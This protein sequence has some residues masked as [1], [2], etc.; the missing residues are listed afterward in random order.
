MN[1]DFLEDL[2]E[3]ENEEDSQGLVSF[4][5]LIISK[6]KL[7]FVTFLFIFINS[8]LYTTYK[9]YFQPLYRGR[10]T[11]LIT[12]PLKDKQSNNFGL[13]GQGD[14][15]SKL[16]LNTT[17]NDTTTL[18]EVLKSQNIIKPIAEKYN[19]KPR[20]LARRIKIKVGGG[21]KRFERAEGILKVSLTGRRP[22]KT[23]VILEDLSELYLQTA[24][25][26]RQKKLSDGLQFLNDQ[27]PALKDKTLEI[28]T[29]LEE[30]RIKNQLIEPIIESKILK[31]NQINFENKVR[32]LSSEKERLKRIREEIVKGNL[33]A[34]S[35]KKDIIAT[36]SENNFRKNGLD[37]V[38]SNQGLLE[39]YSKLEMQISKA[40]TVFKS[41]SKVMRSLKSKLNQL[42][43]ILMKNQ[44]ETVDMA[45]EL[46]ES[47]I[48]N[49]KTQNELNSR[50]FL[51]KPSLIKEYETLQQTL[52]IVSANLKALVEAREILQLEIAQNSF[53][54]SII[55]D[56]IVGKIPISPSVPRNILLGFLLSTAGGVSSVILRNKLDNVYHSSSEIEKALTLPILT[57]I[58]FLKELEKKNVIPKEDNLNSEVDNKQRYQ[59][60]FYSESFRELYTSLRF[61]FTN[62]DIKILA[63]TSSIPSEGKSITA[64]MIAKTLVEFDQKVLIVDSDLRRPTIHKKMEVD[65]IL[66]LS[67]YLVDETLSVKNVIQK[68]DKIEGLDFITSG[69]IPPNP[70]RL[71]ESARFKN[72]LGEFKNNKVYDYDY[73]IFDT[74]PVLGIVDTSIVASYCDYSVLIVSLD[75]VDKRL[76]LQAVKNLK[77]SNKPTIGTIVNTTKE[78]TE[79]V[80]N[81]YG[82][83]KYGYGKYGYKY[84]RNYYYSSNNIEDP[85]IKNSKNQE[86]QEIL[87]EKLNISM[88]IEKIKTNTKKFLKWIDDD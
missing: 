15:I 23:K 76:P 43:P 79:L 39:E 29:K 25:E 38:D 88:I 78:S 26:Q 71:L 32:F 59:R 5:N 31:E 35:F 64:I 65:N 52:N 80:R 62:N 34:T 75:S 37:I 8:I 47:E 51:S 16:A 55:N 44:L 85:E 49:I 74:P 13:G 58:P 72:F 2:N 1:S 45:L 21:T 17:S 87:K 22:K 42:K 83:G 9:Y 53:P 46:N 77:K 40:S 63:V 7:F 10:F 24:L 66:G 82:I 68:S 81:K 11:L 6:K 56:P 73:V 67:N 57:Q 12:D 20:S 60:F 33:I 50:E 27:E 19:I 48:E 54:W 70:P 4:I 36:P 3:G 18:I 28:Q 69:Q 86:N 84:G 30:F 61:L 14:I 41:D